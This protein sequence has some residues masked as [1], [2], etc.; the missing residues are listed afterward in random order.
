MTISIVSCE[1]CEKDDGG[2][3]ETESVKDPHLVVTVDAIDNSSESD[4]VFHAV[5]CATL[6]PVQHSFGE[7][8]VQ[9]TEETFQQASGEVT[10]RVTFQVDEVEQYH[11]DFGPLS[12]SCGCV[13]QLNKIE[14]EG[15][16]GE[17]INWVDLIF[18][19]DDG[20]F[21]DSIRV[22]VSDGK[23]DLGISDNEQRV[24]G[25]LEVIV[26]IG[27]ANPE[28]LIFSTGGLAIVV[29]I[30]GGGH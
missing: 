25:S 17:N 11:Y 20:T 23:I 9:V 8:N 29:D 1:P 27:D 18:T 4:A 15:A 22:Q 10:N 26:D 14:I 12:T 21:Q 13:T 6:F 2:G 28:S 30:E 3:D 5:D 24:D 19:K 16:E 7:D